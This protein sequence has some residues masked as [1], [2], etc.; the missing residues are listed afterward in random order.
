M[1]VRVRWFMLG[2]VASLGAV[3]YMANQLRRVRERLTV[4]NVGREAGR[5]LAGAL[6]SV[7][8]AIAPPADS[9]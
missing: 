5:A 7:A 8:G 1:F 6:D 4:A 2:V 9:R 3:A